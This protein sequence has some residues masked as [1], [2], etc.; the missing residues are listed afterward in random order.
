MKPG[1][2][3]R[4]LC[5]STYMKLRTGRDNLMVMKVRV[6]VAIEVRIALGRGTRA[7][8]LIWVVATQVAYVSK[9]LPSC[10]AKNVHVTVYKSY[11]NKEKKN[12]KKK[13]IFLLLAH[14]WLS[15]LETIDFH[16]FADKYLALF[17]PAEGLASNKTKENKTEFIMALRLSFLCPVRSVLNF[18][19]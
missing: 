14:S 8:I 13:K 1:T 15:I 4:I 19:R 6:V 9:N 10:T 12:P 2:K 18:R 3:V 16:D 5:D 11:L 17:W 7:L